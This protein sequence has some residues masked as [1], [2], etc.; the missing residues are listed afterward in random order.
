MEIFLIDRPYE[1]DVERIDAGLRK[2]GFAK[3]GISRGY[4]LDYPGLIVNLTD[5]AEGKCQ[6][7]GDYL[8]DLCEKGKDSRH[9][10]TLAKIVKLFRPGR[11][12]D[13]GFRD[14]FPELI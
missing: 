5:A 14:I 12:I 10:S 1:H 8:D 11:I 7:Q 2:L 4:E 13:P 6:I 3:G 9:Y